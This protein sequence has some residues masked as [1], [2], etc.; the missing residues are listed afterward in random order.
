MR[1]EIRGAILS[2]PKLFTPEPGQDGGVPQYSA[3]FVVPQDAV[4]KISGE[5]NDALRP[6]QALLK[7]AVSETAKAE[8]G[9]KVRET[10][11]RV[12]H[13]PIR[14][15]IEDRGYPEGS[16]FIN[17]K[18]FGKATAVRPGVVDGSLQEVTNPDL[19]Y[20]GK[21]VNALVEVFAG[22]HPSG[23]PYVTWALRGTQLIRD[24]DRL[25]NYVDAAEAFD[26][27][28]DAVADLSDLTGEDGNTT[29]AAT[30]PA[31]AEEDDLS[32]LLG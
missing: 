31:G 23:G 12:K 17:A 9:A 28:P 22:K 26:S 25:D 1:L 14:T 19:A 8:W 7:Q 5:G 10:F 32:D 15:D 18:T 2:Y 29:V 4:A 30:A 24:G 27:D 11:K 16:V 6:A 3:C 20:P 13:S 21:I